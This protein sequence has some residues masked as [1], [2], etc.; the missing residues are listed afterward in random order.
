MIEDVQP[1]K[2]TEP[3]TMGKILREL[4]DLDIL[5]KHRQFIV[6]TSVVGKANT[7]GQAVIDN[8]SIM[9]MRMKF[10]GQPIKHDQVVAIAFYDPPLPKPD[11]NLRFTPAI[12]LGRGMPLAGERLD[13][14]LSVLYQR[15]STYLTTFKEFFPNFPN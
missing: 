8:P 9:N 15:T 11:P 2:G 3:G 10:T 14:I 5:D 6:T 12:T 4:A 13:G 1:Y 7:S